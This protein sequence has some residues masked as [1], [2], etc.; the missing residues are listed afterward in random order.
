MKKVLSILLSLLMIISAVSA[1]SLCVNA[2]EISEFAINLDMSKVHLNTAYT[3]YE[4]YNAVNTTICS[5]DCDG[6]SI[7]MCQV[8]YYDATAKTWRSLGNQQ[9][10]LSTAKLYGAYVSVAFDDGYEP[11]EVVKALSVKDYLISSCP[12]LKLKVN[13]EYRDDAYFYYYEAG[14]QMRFYIPFPAVSD[15]PIIKEVEIGINHLSLGLGESYQLSAEAFGTADNKNIVWSIS[16]AT[17]ANT[18]IAADGTLTIGEDESTGYKTVR[19]ASEFDESVYDEISVK[20]INQPAV[21]TGVTVSPETAE[22]VQKSHKQFTAKVSGTQMET[23]ITWSLEGNESD[24]TVIN[25][26]G[27]LYVAKDE[28]AQTLTVKATSNF[29]NTKFGV[30]TV[31]VTPITILS[32]F[33]VEYDEAAFLL[34]ADHTEGEVRTNINNNSTILVPGSKATE[35]YIGYLNGSSFNGIG[36]GTNQVSLE[37]NYYVEY[38]S[39]LEEGYDWCDVILNTESNAKPVSEVEGFSVIAN[40]EVVEDAYVSYNDYWN[41][42]R[43][44]IP[45]GPATEHDPVEP[46]DFPDVHESDWFYEAVQY[47][48]QKGFI[49]G[50]KNGKFGPRRGFNIV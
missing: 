12:V 47:C 36:Y 39:E 29:D 20:V 11:T 24:A 23:S 9:V 31:T 14:N 43:V 34:S 49:T 10:P 25:E 1:L 40:G 48:A 7:K 22:V 30:A 32:E 27:K 38:Y 50:Y 5:P 37:R 13:G 6:I 35:S 46:I 26:Y 17:S 33:A 2:E 8:N 18:A 28:T 45:I 15:A 21:I 19:A 44:Y 41:A 42:V 4:L 16:D 3:E